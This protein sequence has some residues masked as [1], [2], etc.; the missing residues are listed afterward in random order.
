MKKRMRRFAAVLMMICTFG[1]SGIM[2]NAAGWPSYARN[3]S[4]NKSFTETGTQNDPYS[5]MD[6]CYMDIFRFQVP[7]S[8]TITLKL[9]GKTDSVPCFHIYKTTNTDNSLWFGYSGNRAGYD[10]DYGTNGFWSKWSFKLGKGNYYL[11]VLHGSD[12]MNI[13]YTYNIGFSPTF[14]AS[15][16]T[17]VTG[18]AKSMLVRWRKAGG[19]NGYQIQYSLYSNMKSAK[20]VTVNNVSATSRVIKGLK[21]GRRYYVRIRSYKKVKE[22]GKTK[23]YYKSWSSIKKVVVK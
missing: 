14:S 22:S 13:R 11:M 17:G 12:T 3:V 4:L 15:S 19:A 2:A 5:L 21:S 16:V 6:A 18:R 10:Y 23:T 9:K 7:A 20:T 8:G 1:A